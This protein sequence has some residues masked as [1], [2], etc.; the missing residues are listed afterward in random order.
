VIRMAIPACESGFTVSDFN[1]AGAWRKG[2]GGGVMLLRAGGER[3]QRDQRGP[4]P[5]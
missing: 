1:S 4:D 3:D 2:C 5:E